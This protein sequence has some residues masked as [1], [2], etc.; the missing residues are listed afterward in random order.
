M[1]FQKWKLKISYNF[2]IIAIYHQF[3]KQNEQLSGVQSA[4]PPSSVLP[5]EK[6]STAIV[7]FISVLFLP[8]IWL[9]YENYEIMN[10]MN[11]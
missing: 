2:T 11:E 8:N 3:I 6:G 5:L 10:N 7:C 4:A 1:Y 9:I